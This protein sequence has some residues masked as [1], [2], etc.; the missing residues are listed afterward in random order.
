MK[1]RERRRK[2]SS[3]KLSEIGCI[4]LITLHHTWRCITLWSDLMESAEC[5]TQNRGFR[6]SVVA[7][8]V[9]WPQSNCVGGCK[10]VIARASAS[11]K[12][13][14][15]NRQSRERERY[16]SRGCWKRLAPLSGTVQT[17]KTTHKCQRSPRN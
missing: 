8:R 4:T 5:K 13:A 11:G 12:D 2:T 6:E 15:F 16:K 7:V 14:G 3:L 10:G 9:S 17:P 1:L